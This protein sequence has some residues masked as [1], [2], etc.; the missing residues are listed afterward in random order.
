MALRTVESVRSSLPRNLPGNIQKLVDRALEKL[1]KQPTPLPV[2]IAPVYRTDTSAPKPKARQVQLQPSDPPPAGLE[3]LPPPPPDL[4]GGPTV[5]PLPPQVL[6]PTP[7]TPMYSPLSL[8]GY[9]PPITSQGAYGGTGIGGISIGPGGITAQGTLFGVPIS[10]TLPFGG[11]SRGSEPA[12]NS[13]VAPTGGGSGECPGIMSV[14]DP[15]TG[16]CINLD[17]LPPGG[18]PAITGSYTPAGYADGYGAAVKGIYGVGLVPRVEV[19]TVRRC[20]AGMALGKDGVCYEGLGRNSKKRA[21]PM[22]MKPLMTAGDRAA[23]RKASSAA[24][25]L[26]RSKKQ[27]K[28]ASRALEK[29]GC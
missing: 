14:K 23:I 17:A 21:W 7:E 15:I 24:A 6:S 3:V 29:A 20:P 13:L 5:L 11:S 26:Q 9:T 22:G 4:P 19:Q 18:K 10:G 8:G 28:R 27:L 12:G 16:Q 2:P 1:E 25:K